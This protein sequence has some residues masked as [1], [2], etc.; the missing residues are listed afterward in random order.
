MSL[1]VR[2]AITNSSSVD[3]GDVFT[4]ILDDVE[5]LEG[6]RVTDRI[7]DVHRPRTGVDDRTH[8]LRHE[9]EVGPDRVLAGE[10]HVGGI[11]G[12]P[13]DRLD[14]RIQHL[15]GLHL[16]LVLHVDIGGGDEGVDPPLLPRVLQRLPAPVDILGV[17]PAEPGYLR[18]LDGLGYLSDRLEVPYGGDGK[19]GLDHIHVELLQLPGDPHLFFHVHAGAGRL[20]AVPQGSV[21]YLYRL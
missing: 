16:Q 8:H 12:S 7:R 5:I 2:S 13:L 21:E 4:E 10:L 6:D 3:V 11:G 17:C 9:L 14:R 19:P 1:R 18:S 15:G 20:L